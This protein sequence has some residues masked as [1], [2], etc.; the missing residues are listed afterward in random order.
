MRKYIAII[1]AEALLCAAAA[2]FIPVTA[3]GGFALAEQFPLAQIGGILR[4]LSLSGG[5]G[6]VFAVA[7]YAAI[8]LVPAVFVV[9][10]L[11]RKKAKPEDILLAVLTAYLFYAVYMMINPAYMGSSGLGG[12]KIGKSVLGGV[13]W[14]VL[15]SW[16]VLRLMRF[17]KGK[18]TE[19]VLN[20]MSILLI[21][22]VIFI[23]FFSAYVNLTDLKT[24]IKNLETGNNNPLDSVSFNTNT[25]EMI[26]Y[27]PLMPTKAILI[28]KYI[29]DQI[30]AAMDIL[31]LLFANKLVQLLKRDRY[32]EEV[33]K[34]SGK[35]AA[36]C[37]NAVIITVL[38]AVAV[39]LLQIL[40]A[41]SL[42]ASDY[43]ANIPLFSIILALGM[44]LLSRYLK[45]SREIKRENDMF[46]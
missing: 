3:A 7:L 42:R 46:V 23:I 26:S 5:I 29:I 31:I 18:D 30:P 33:V 24:A 36:L 11:C 6:N 1:A 22:S 19:N 13:F 20:M 21:V 32:G 40:F 28:I 8:C 38:S 45:E 16:L 12:E 37:K 41:E 4:A 27:D 15:L 9:I 10:G 17:V 14:S 44:L 34:A 39:N 2:I 43:T 35:L 25:G